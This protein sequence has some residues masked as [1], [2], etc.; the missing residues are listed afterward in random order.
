MNS[1]FAHVTR[2][3]QQLGG[4]DSITRA[5]EAVVSAPKHAVINDLRAR[6][7]DDACVRAHPIHKYSPDDADAS[8]FLC[9]YYIPLTILIHASHG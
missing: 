6:T 9:V 1:C 7:Y 8:V 4:G 2:H 5:E 3:V